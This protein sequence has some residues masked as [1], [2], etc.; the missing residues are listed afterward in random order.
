MTT[1][2]LHNGLPKDRQPVIRVVPY[3]RDTNPA[4]DIFGGWIMS[5]VDVAGS[6]VASHCANGRVATVAVNEFQFKKPVFV[7]DLVSCYGEVTH[8]GKTS[9]TVDV[10]VYVQRGWRAGNNMGETIKVTE[11][12]LTYVAIDEN[13]QKRVLTKK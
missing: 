1:S 9:V 12:N 8:V 7:G 5:Q 11:A 6:I 13:G 4:G 3:P 2:T 10:S